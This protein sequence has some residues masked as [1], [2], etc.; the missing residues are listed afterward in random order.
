VHQLGDLPELRQYLVHEGWAAPADI[1]IERLA[2][3]RRPAPADHRTGDMG[4]AH[5]ATAGLP[6]DVLE[7]EPDAER[8]EA[9]DHLP[10]APHPIGPATFQECLEIG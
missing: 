4:P 8:L 9:G 10:A 3:I 2:H 1:A 6:Q 7:L 5:R